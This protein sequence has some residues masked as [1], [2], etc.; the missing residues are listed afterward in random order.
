MRL[1]LVLALVAIG[2]EHGQGGGLG[3]TCSGLSLLDC[4]LAAGCQ[5]DL[6]FACFCDQSYR[7]CISDQA[8]PLPCPELGCPGAECCSV[9]S[10]CTNGATCAPPGSPQGCG[11]C[12]TTPGDCLDD[13]ECVGTSICEPIQCSCD[14]A[15][16]CVPGC[17]DDGDCPAE[18][19][20]C[21]LPSSRCVAAPCALDDECPSNF[22]CDGSACTRVQC[23][24]DL[25]CDGFCVVGS[26]FSGAR[27]ECRLPSA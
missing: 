12:N 6:C 13:S 22:R 5:P 18:G 2:C 4:R 23:T 1:L 9:D 8:D 26:C 16:Q 19:T 17:L 11:A 10:Q 3:G 15:L 7:G 14:A 25:D 27:G 24:D 21:D 20:I